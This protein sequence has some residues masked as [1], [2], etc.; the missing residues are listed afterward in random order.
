MQIRDISKHAPDS[1]EACI[2]PHT[3]CTQVKDIVR[4][5]SSLFIEIVPEIEMPGH[6]VAALAAYPQISCESLLLM[7]L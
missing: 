7:S 3:L 5:A 1:Y 4:H 6:C 2:G